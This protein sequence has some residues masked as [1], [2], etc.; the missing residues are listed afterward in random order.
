MTKFCHNFAFSCHSGKKAPGH[1]SGVIGA[2]QVATLSGNSGNN[3]LTGTSGADLISGQAGNDSLYGG[4]GNDTLIGGTGNDRL[5]GGTGTDTAD[6]SGSGAGVSVNLSTGTGSGGDAQ[7]DQLS[8]IENLVGSAYADTLTGSGSANLLE[9]GAGNDRIDAGGGD[10][11]LIGGAGA[12]SLYGGSGTDLADYSGSGAGVSV[13]LASGTGQGGD[14][15]GDVLSGIEQVTG[16][17]FADTLTG[18]GAANTLDGGAGDD[19]LSGG[20]GSDALYG[21]AGNDT[22]TGGSGSDGLYGGDGSDTA[23]YSGSGA[24]VSVN[25]STGTGS[26]G[27]AAGDTLSGIETLIGSAYND[28]LTGDAGQNLL[29]GGDGRDLLYGGDGD[30]TLAGGAGADTLYGGEDLDIAD[31]SGS[32]AAVNVN[33]TDWTATGGHATGDVL[34][35][36]DGLIGSA[37]DDTLIGYDE[38]GLSGDVYTNAFYGGAGNDLMDGRGGNDS[39]YGGSGND[40]V[41]GGAGDDTLAGDEG[42]DLLDAGAGNDLAEGGA[43]NDTVSGGAGD[44]S[45]YGGAG[46]DS[47]DGGEGND[48]LYGGEGNDTLSGGAG[49]DLLEGGAGDDR[50]LGGA[51]ADTLYGGD[52]NDTLTGDAGDRLY[53]GAGDDLLTGSGAATLIGGDGSDTLLGGAGLVVDGSEDVDDMDVLDLTGL[54]PLRVL[55]DPQNPENGTVTFYNG[56]GQPTGTM[57]FVNIEQVI[58]CF[59]PGARIAC[60][61]GERRVEDL[62]AGDRVMTRDHGLQPIRWVG[63]K[64]LGAADLAADPRL[65]PVRI[66][67]G[68]LGG[69]LPLRAMQVSRQHRML[70]AGPRAELLF[71]ADEVLVRAEHLLGLPGVT[72]AAETEVTYLH[73]LFD[74]HEVVLADGAW[75]ESFQPGDRTVGGLDEAARDELLTLFPELA[76]LGGAWPAARP[77]LKRFEAKV[78]LAA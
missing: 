20:S 3:S 23:D 60:E 62:R 30:D 76:G 48:R 18:D 8:S 64:R 19:L 14:A 71:G 75:S 12:D 55:Y 73:L 72:E 26:G 11:T 51:G 47:L 35:G 56:L 39:L 27:D 2:V 21:G 53:G 59:T 46:R 68:A 37:F 42:H 5:Y 13:N 58:A 7:G 52:G 33:L 38:M 69:G 6:Y 54:G 44:D 63:R 43:G 4:S 50:L 24:G 70:M 36:I 61:G 77:T 40:T 29:A 65:Q 45:L 9:G 67:A 16:T 17:D 31:Y 41:Y 57:N 28:T 1:A 34:S 32:N 15:Q 10:D 49:N 22:L 78:L 25:L 66:A 74:R